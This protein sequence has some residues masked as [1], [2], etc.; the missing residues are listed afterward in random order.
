MPGEFFTFKEVL[1]ELQIDQNELQRLITQGEI[2]AYRDASGLKFKDEDVARLKKARETE[3]TV[4]LT[5]SDAAISLPSEEEL[6]VE[7]GA[8]GKGTVL[9]VGG[10]ETEEIPTIIKPP[11]G[12][13]APKPAEEIEP[14]VEV[15]PT[16]VAKV[17][18]AKEVDEFETIGPTRVGSGRISRSARLR[19]LQMKR[20]KSHIIWTVLIFITTIFILM[21]APFIL[22]EMR[23]T[24]PKY[25]VDLSDNVRGLA[26]WIFSLTK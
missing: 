18:A 25:A 12:E 21:S 17:A 2:R 5:D 1:Q 8:K 6:I 16:V 10:L 22:N 23:S 3:P 9:D 11:A 15:A 13:E 20:K 7:E 4:I 14:V 24:T 26:D 19:L